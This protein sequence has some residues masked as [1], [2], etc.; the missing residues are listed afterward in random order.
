MAQSYLMTIDQSD[1]KKNLEAGAYTAIVLIALALLLFFVSWQLPNPV[2]PDPPLAMQG[3]EVNLG[4]MET[5]SGDDQPME[6]G[7]PAPAVS[8]SSAGA[9]AESAEDDAS[10]DADSD[11]SLPKTNTTKPTTKPTDVTKSATKPAVNP[12]PAPPKP[13]ITMPN[14]RTSPNSNGPGGNAADSYQ[15]GSNQGIAGGKGDQGKPGGDPN[16]DSYKGDGRGSGG[17]RIKSGLGGRSITGKYTFVDEFNR[18]ATVYVDVTVD[19]AGKVSNASINLSRTTTTDR[20]IKD[21]AIQRAYQLK[22]NPGKEEQKGTLAIEFK[23]NG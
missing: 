8:N 6:P 14:G 11:V 2:E 17:I 9:P 20:R 22:F 4:T 1:K 19:A 21:I 23:V 3:I 7:E 5:G 13:K 10:D 15:K 18:N 16:S 12:T